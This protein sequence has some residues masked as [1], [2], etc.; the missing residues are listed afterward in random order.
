M[1]S[2]LFAAK[3]LPKPILSCCQLDPKEQNYSE[4]K[5]KIFLQEKASDNVIGKMAAISPVHWKYGNTLKLRQN[6]L[7]HF[8]YDIFKLIFFLMKTFKFKK[9]IHWNMFLNSLWPNDAIWYGNIDLCQ[10]WFR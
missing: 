2:Y 9:K 10:H 7:V 8:A 5:Y 4:Y 6:G 3:Q 1:A